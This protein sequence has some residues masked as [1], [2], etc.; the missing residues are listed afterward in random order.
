[1]SV[2]PMGG[3]DICGCNLTPST[4]SKEQWAD[5]FTNAEAGN[6]DYNSDLG[7]DVY[8]LIIGELTRVI[9]P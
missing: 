4:D 9:S 3:N 8:V 1:M 6:I 2:E 5:I 7:A